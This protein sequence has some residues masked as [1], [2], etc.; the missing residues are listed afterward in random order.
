MHQP[1]VSI[2]VPVYNAEK[3][4]RRCVDS[5]LGQEFTDFELL[6]VDDG[7]TDDSPAILDAY[8]AAD[9]RVTVI[10]KPNSG[11]SATRNLALGKAKG[12]YIQF[13]DA[14]DWIT[15]DATKL[16]VRSALENNA[17]MVI[18]DFYRV[19]GDDVARKG[20]IGGDA[21]SLSR[22]EYADLMMKD[23]ADFYYG[24]IWNK[25]YRASIIRDHGVRMDETLNWCEDF[26]FNLEYVLH[27]R[28]V[29]VLRSPIYYYVKTEG[30]LVSHTDLTDVVRMKRT[31]LGYY[32]DFYR[33][34]FDEDEY[35]RRRTDIYRYL[36]SFATDDSA[37]GGMPGTTKLGRERVPGYVPA[38]AQ[39]NPFLGVYWAQRVLDRY[40]DRVAEQNDLTLKQARIMAYLRYCPGVVDMAAL[41]DFLQQTRA[42]TMVDLQRLN[43]SGLIDLQWR[44]GGFEASF[45]VPRGEQV[46]AGIDHVAA[47]FESM[48]APVLGAAG[49]AGGDGARVAAERGGAGARRAD[50]TDG[51]Q[52]SSAQDARAAAERLLN[53]GFAALA[54]A[55]NKSSTMQLAKQTAVAKEAA[56]L[57]AQK[58]T[59]SGDSYAGDSHSDGSRLAGM[60]LGDSHPGDVRLSDL[61]PGDNSHPGNSHSDD[62]SSKEPDR[63]SHTAPRRERHV[64]KSLKQAAEEAL[65]EACEEAAREVGEQREMNEQ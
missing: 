47:D 9:Q 30:S 29:A 41:A 50:A 11:V 2:I 64:H 58:A 18:A 36:V 3:G 8:A 62:T 4:I 31:V 53:D 33:S 43:M 22:Q 37:I 55:L 65:E 14:D 52:Y 44:D 39:P 13:L 16:L 40:L 6:L 61:Y 19:V 12:T 25:L 20:Q 59:H 51:A 46:A 57:K 35:K 5:I 10:H 7:S 1:T 24:V 15:E 23:P 49:G 60:Y 42:T 32:R 48:L 45:C 38:G 26:I 17:D 28:T 34:V 27:V 63:E 54:Q 56:N 21:T